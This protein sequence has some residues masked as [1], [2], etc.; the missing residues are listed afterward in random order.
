MNIYLDN[1]A[2]T[3]PK[4]EVIDA[5]MPYFTDKWYNPSSL[6]SNAHSVKNDIQNAKKTIASYIC[7]QENEIYFTSGGSESNCWAIQGFINHC[8]KNNKC[9]AIITTRIEHKSILDC[10]DNVNANVFY[11]DVDKFG[12]VK[13]EDLSECLMYCEEVGYTTLVSIQMANNEIGTIQYIRRLSSIVHLYHAILHTDAVQAFGKIPINVDNYYVDLM[14]VS[15]HKFGCPKGIGFLYIRN[16]IEIEPLIYGTQMNGMRG[17][18]ENVPYIIGMAKA[19]ELLDDYRK[20]I[21]RIFVQSENKHFIAI[22]KLNEALI[23]KF[24]CK[25]NGATSNLNRVHGIMS[26]RFPNNIHIESLILMLD[27][28]NICISAGSACNT[29]SDKPSHVL[30]AIGLSDEECMN[31]M[32]LSFE[33]NSLTEEKV[34]KFIDS[35]EKAIKIMKADVDM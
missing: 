25:I 34:D 21:T 19:V 26:Y 30:K 27:M 35:L 10:V 22:A 13:E 14:S 2:T 31:T 4:Q 18:T 1:A 23:N 29:Y 8:H 32:R 28:D 12:F 33:Y 9:P 24:G 20:H 3:K 15:G 7:A 16:G 11:I 17:G 6:Y 5:M